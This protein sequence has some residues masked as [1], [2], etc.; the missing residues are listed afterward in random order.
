VVL[1]LIDRMTS[2]PV[3]HARHLRCRILELKLTG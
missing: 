3:V 1:D 2:I